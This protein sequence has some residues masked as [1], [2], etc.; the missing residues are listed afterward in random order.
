[1]SD[2]LMDKIRQDLSRKNITDYNISLVELDI[3]NNINT[4]DDSYINCTNSIIYVF[5]TKAFDTHTALLY[6]KE[7]I[8]KVGDNL[9]HTIIKFISDIHYNNFEILKFAKVDLIH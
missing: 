9:N 1:M 7:N 2:L 8:W 5:E 3:A 6:S 4:T